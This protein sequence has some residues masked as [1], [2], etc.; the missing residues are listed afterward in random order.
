MKDVYGDYRCPVCDRGL[1]VVT[2]VGYWFDGKRYC[3]Y[4]CMMQAEKAWKSSTEYKIIQEELRGV[5]IR[6]PIY[7]DLTDEEAKDFLAMFKAGYSLSAIAVKFNRSYD[8][9]RRVLR[10]EGLI[11]PKPSSLTK[12]E[13]ADIKRRVANGERLRVIADEMKLSKTTIGRAARGDL[14]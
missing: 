4:S 11:G 8:S 12:Q 3:S 6:E 13:I 10:H 5:E 9:V 2:S 7:R 1:S 14:D